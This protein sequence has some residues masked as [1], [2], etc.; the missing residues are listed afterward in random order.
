MK[1]DPGHWGSRF[2]PKSKRYVR[3]QVNDQSRLITDEQ[4]NRSIP[5]LAGSPGKPN[6]FGHIN[7]RTAERMSE[8]TKGNK[9]TL[10]TIRQLD[11][12]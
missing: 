2:I 5:G 9:D 7:E 10:E 6:A 1:G 12:F 4:R 8:R 11:L 3:L